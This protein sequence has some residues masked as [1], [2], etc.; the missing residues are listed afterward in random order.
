MTHDKKFLNQILVGEELTEDFMS[1]KVQKKVDQDID[2]FVFGSRE[3]T[4]KQHKDA[5]QD[6]DEYVFGPRKKGGK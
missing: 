2:E 1:G 3:K 4:E 6:V 5:S